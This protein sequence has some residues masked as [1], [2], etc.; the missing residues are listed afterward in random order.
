MD[1]IMKKIEKKIFEKYKRK[2][3]RYII[4]NSKY[5]NI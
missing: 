1:K 2:A 4:S 5:L 3:H